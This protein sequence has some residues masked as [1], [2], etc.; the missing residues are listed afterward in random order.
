M[1]NE[2]RE[3][4]KPVTDSDE[5]IFEDLEDYLNATLVNGTLPG[6]KDPG[7]DEQI[8]GRGS[9]SRTQGS[10]LDPQ[11]AI[12]KTFTLNFQLKEGFLNWMILFM[13]THMFMD[14][15]KRADKR[16]FMGDIFGHILDENDNIMIE[17]IFGECRIA[18]IPSIDLDKSESGFGDVEKFNVEVAY[19][20]LVINFKGLQTVN[21]TTKDHQF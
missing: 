7:S 5:F 21:W 2:I 6:I 8:Q 13:Q 12:E 18:S 3:Y 16:M 14:R 9:L 15:S 11:R 19:N 4:L 1:F 17:L 10:A 20:T